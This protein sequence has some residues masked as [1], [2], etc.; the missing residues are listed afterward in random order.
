[1]NPNTYSNLFSL[2]MK[3]LDEYLSLFKRQI[4]FLYFTFL[5]ISPLLTILEENAK[6][7]KYPLEISVTKVIRTE[8]FYSEMFMNYRLLWTKLVNNCKEFWE[9]YQF[10]LKKIQ[11]QVKVLNPVMDNVM[12][13][14]DEAWHDAYDKNQNSTLNV[15]YLENTKDFQDIHERLKEEGRSHMIND[16]ICEM[17]S[18]SIDFSKQ[19][20]RHEKICGIGVPCGMCRQT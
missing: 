18:I 16:V 9:L 11:K 13:Q 1:M 15:L 17:G 4:S 20:I 8:I 6:K 2:N 5:R 7:R 14:V 19:K 10:I 3:D 12:S